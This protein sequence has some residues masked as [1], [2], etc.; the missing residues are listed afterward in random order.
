MRVLVYGGREFGELPKSKPPHEISPGVYSYVDP[1]HPDY[2]RKKKE[3]DFV[4][5]ELEIFA[6]ENSV[7]YVPDDNW[8]PSDIMIISGGA[9]GVD[10]IAI[11]WA[12]VNW[13]PFKEYPADW[14]K[15][16]KKA[17]YLRNIQMRDEGQPDI[18]L[19]FP[20]G[21]GTAMMTTLLKEKGI[22]VREYQY[23][24]N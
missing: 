1:N 2:E 10:S 16:G 24:E 12:V 15:H 9:R 8:L 20:G 19:A 7:H 4:L 23:K 17:G 14:E 6:Q 3:R 22:P 5:R 18:G 11:D 21:K 13:C